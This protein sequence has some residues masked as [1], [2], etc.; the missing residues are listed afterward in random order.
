M[1]TGE[2]GQGKEALAKLSSELERQAD[3]YK[4]LEV[5]KD[6]IMKL[7]APRPE[8][9]PEELKIPVVTL[10]TSVDLKRQADFAGIQ[11]D[12]DLSS[13]HDTAGGIT[14][15]QPHLIWMQDGSKYLGKSFKW[16]RGHLEKNERPDTKYDGVAFGIVNPDF[17]A[18]L[19]K[20]AIDLP[21]TAVESGHAPYLVGWD[22]RPRFNRHFV[23]IAFPSFGSATCAG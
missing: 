3:I 14:F 21:G 23:N 2:L 5:N 12:Y 10:G 16:V 18:L 8:G 9:L 1:F 15:G 6:T 4:G 22:G 20:H 11:T 7:L 17:P 13:G 19:Q